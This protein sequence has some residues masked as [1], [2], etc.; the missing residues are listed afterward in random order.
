MTRI[1]LLAAIMLALAPAAAVNAQQLLSENDIFAL[2]CMGVFQSATRSLSQYCP[3]GAE[4]ACQSEG[5]KTNQAGLNRVKR[6]LS[7]RGYLPSAQHGLV[8]RMALAIGGGEDDETECAQWR[9]NNP[10]AVLEGR[11]EPPSCKQTD[12]CGNLSRL[13]M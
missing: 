2:Y 7:A 4:Q 3:T 9:M 5:Y 10:Q 13:P 6:Y 1:R 8:A 12:K 11:D